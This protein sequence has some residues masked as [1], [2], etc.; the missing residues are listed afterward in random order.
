M[1]EDAKL[2]L[3]DHLGL[4]CGRDSGDKHSG[5]NHGATHTHHYRYSRSAFIAHL[6]SRN[7]LIDFSPD[8]NS[9]LK[10]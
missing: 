5:D 10:L 9:R 4:R 2:E 1:G 7:Q 8:A 6:M 3:V